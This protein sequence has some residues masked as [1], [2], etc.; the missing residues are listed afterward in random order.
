HQEALA[1]SSHE[2]ERKEKRSQIEQGVEKMITNSIGMEL[3][4]IP[5]T[6][7]KMGSSEAEQKV[8]LEQ[9]YEKEKPDWLTAE[10]PQ[11]EVE[12]RQPFYLGKYT[13]T[14]K[15]FRLIMGYNPSYFSRDGRRREG[16]QYTD[17]P[18][19]GKE[20]VAAKKDS[21]LEDFPVENVSWE[22]AR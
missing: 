10:G 5:K 4:L 17:E 19:G 11:H 3:R 7:F 12:I 6:K 22:E 13:V 14:Q 21:E 9:I 15:Q 2:I 20:K 18:A 16:E 1:L 8:V